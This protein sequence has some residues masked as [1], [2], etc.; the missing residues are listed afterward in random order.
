M[1]RSMEM[2]THQW[3]SSVILTPSY[4]MEVP[5]RT[6]IDTAAHNRHTTILIGASLLS[7]EPSRPC[8]Q[9]S[10]VFRMQQARNMTRSTPPMKAMTRRMTVTTHWGIWPRQMET[11]QR[12]VIE[13]PSLKK[14]TWSMCLLNTR[15]MVVREKL[16]DTRAKSWL[17]KT[18]SPSIRW[19]KTT[20]TRTRR[21]LRSNKSSRT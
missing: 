14:K 16:R 5:M 6:N 12:R 13:T 11:R 3:S 17:L 2:G 15:G 18:R 19:S 9:N 21:S 8:L 1:Y 20:R 10:R 7:T 4:P